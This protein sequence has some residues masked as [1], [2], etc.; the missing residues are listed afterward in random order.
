MAR[1]RA[2]VAAVA[3][4][5]VEEAFERGVPSTQFE[6]HLQPIVELSSGALVGA[7]S[8]VRWRHPERG[9]VPAL[10]WIPHAEERG[11]LARCAAGLAPAWIDAARSTGLAIGFNLSDRQL[12]D[13]E[14]AAIVASASHGDGR[15]A[16]EIHQSQFPDPDVSNADEFDRALR[17]LRSS[18]VEVWLDDFGEHDL[19]DELLDRTDLDV[20]KLDR[21]SLAW[22]ADRLSSVVGRVHRRGGLVTVE[23]IESDDHLLTARTTGADAGQGFRFGLPTPVD[24]F[25]ARAVSGGR[26]RP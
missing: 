6:L 4:Q 23:G 3:E 15:L 21:S 5:W 14:F 17:E 26:G 25:V 8:F 1:T 24:A 16:V 2:S 18:G 9:V 13:P 22:A 20:V 7:E 10:A 11:E 12:L 19:G